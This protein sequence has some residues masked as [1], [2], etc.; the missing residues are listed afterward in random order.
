MSYLG[1]PGTMGAQYIDYLI[2]DPT[3]AVTLPAD[4]AFRPLKDGD[5]PLV[6]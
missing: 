5:C 3:L 4:Q 1:Y 2:A 6:K